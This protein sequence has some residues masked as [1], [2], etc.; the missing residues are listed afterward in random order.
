MENGGA[1]NAPI[2]PVDSAKKHLPFQTPQS[3]I[4]YLVNYEDYELNFQIGTGAFGNVWKAYDKKH[5]RTIAIKVLT[6]E[7]LTLRELQHFISEA[8]ILAKAQASRFIVPFYGFSN[9]YPYCLITKLARNGNLNNLI[10]EYKD[11]KS[12]PGSTFTKIAIGVVAGMIHLHSLNIIHR[13]L[14]PSNILLDNDFVPMICDFGISR[15][16]DGSHMTKMAGTPMWMAPEIIEGKDYT[17]SADVF[18]FG[19]LL[20]EMNTFQRPFPMMESM[21]V[22]QAIKNGQRPQIPDTVEKNMRKLIESCWDKDPANRPPFVVIFEKLTKFKA[23][24]QN[25]VKDKVKPFIKEIKLDQETMKRSMSF[26]TQKGRKIFHPLTLEDFIN[27]PEKIDVY[28]IVQFLL[29]TIDYFKGKD[30]Q[31]RLTLLSLLSKAAL[32]QEFT[33][34]FVDSNI[35]NFLPFAEYPNECVEFISRVV[36]RSNDD[37][38]GDMMRG[39][40]NILKYTRPIFTLR[41]LQ[42]IS[43][44]SLTSP[45][46]KILIQDSDSFLYDKECIILYLKI[47]LNYVKENGK[48]SLI[49]ESCQLIFSTVLEKEK[50]YRTNS[51][52]KVDEDVNSNDFYNEI[53]K[54][55]YKGLFFLSENSS[56][57]QSE[58]VQTNYKPNIKLK[59][60]LFHLEDIKIQKYVIRFLRNIDGFPVNK[61]TLISVIN[62]CINQK[63]ATLMLLDIIENN[64]LALDF[65]LKH[66]KWAKNELPDWDSTFQIFLKIFN[67]IQKKNND[68]YNLKLIYFLEYYSTENPDIALKC[69]QVLPKQ[70]F[71][72]NDTYIQLFKNSYIICC[73]FDC[74]VHNR[75]REN[76]TT[77]KKHSQNSSENEKEHSDFYQNRKFALDFLNEFSSF[78]GKGFSTIVNDLIEFLND[79]QIAQSTAETL[80][81][82]TFNKK[83]KRVLRRVNIV[84]Y[85]NDS[86]YVHKSTK[87]NLKLVLE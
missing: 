25:C 14:K 68:E 64:D 44:R 41:V 37:N 84:Q 76:D 32:Q 48:S 49:T 15:T 58:G 77:K 1:A 86:K 16:D 30:Q 33:K 87:R 51:K 45:P 82:I 31:H 69:L 18:S 81:N 52:Q 75:N 67:V 21:K 78:I 12:V 6:K 56:N 28:T 57:I 20:Y 72:N 62:A 9:H 61:K 79:E 47:L 53:M 29:V 35:I 74:F 22:V 59:Q 19:M 7:V 3:L 5:D 55:C 24:F 17:L 73:I 66:K 60:V 39:I 54:L 38:D 2:I 34:T 70:D 80:I 42:S 85:V 36:V 43:M 27:D 13:D 71:L 8:Q 63:N 50:F 83:C 23:C 65:L 46:L 40:R 4:P 26:E 10:S 11:K